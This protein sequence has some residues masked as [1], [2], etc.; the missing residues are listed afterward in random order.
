MHMVQLNH[1]LAVPAVLCAAACSTPRQTATDAAPA[2]GGVLCWSQC[3]VEVK[4]PLAEDLDVY[5]S[6]G[7][8]RQFHGTVAAGVSRTFSIPVATAGSVTLY[9]GA[10]GQQQLFRSKVVEVT[11][12]KP[13]VVDFSVPGYRSAPRD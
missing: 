9:A 5:Y 6:R 7:P 2:P 13:V 1:F 10:P 11:P 3:L 12:D 4:N 8:N